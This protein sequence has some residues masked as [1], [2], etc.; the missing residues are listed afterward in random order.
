MGARHWAAAQITRATD[1]IAVAVSS[2]GGT[3]RVF[4]GGEIVLRI[5]PLERAMTWREFESEH[6]GDK[7]K[8]DKDKP[9]APAEAK[10]PPE[11]KPSKVRSKTPRGKAAKAAAEAK[12][13]DAAAD[14]GG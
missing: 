1:A 7:D 6:D 5:E 3:V 10:K 8:G 9:A 14:A 2:S 11:K 12:A 13:D 4:Q